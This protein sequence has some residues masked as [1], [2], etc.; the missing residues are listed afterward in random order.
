MFYATLVCSVAAALLFLSPTCATIVTNDTSVATNQTFDYVIVGAGLAG[1]TV[2]NKLSGAGN[3]VLII[4]AGPDPRW[5]PAVY[6]AEER[7]NLDGYC[8]WQYPAYDD[9]GNTLDWTIDSGMCIGGGTSINGLMWYRPT[10]AE[11]NKLE[12]LGNPGWNWESLEPYMIAAERNHPPD[13]IQ[14]AQGAGY[15]PSRH[16]YSGAIN[17]SFPTPMRIPTVQSRFKAALPRIFPGLTIG[18]DLS[19]RSPTVSA[20]SSWT[21]WYDPA[22][23]K[24]R[25]SSAAD[26]LLWAEDQWRERLTVLTNHR[27]DRVIFD[28]KLAATGVAFSAGPERPPSVVHA[29]KE[30]ILAAGALQSAPVLERS[31][32]GSKAVLERAGIQQLVDLPGVGA[33]LNDQPGT[34]TSALVR[35]AYW[36][37]TG[38]ID[39]RI[40]FAPEISLVGLDEVWGADA[41]SYTSA[42]TSIEGLESRAQA[43]VSVGAAANIEGAK[44]ILNTTIDLIVNSDQPVAEFIGESYPTIL[45]AAFWPSMPLSRGHVHINDSYPFSTPVITPRLLTDSFDQE[46]AVAI[47]RRSRALF[48][49]DVFEYVVEN[50][51]YDP[52]IGP[53]GTDAEYLEWYKSTAYGASHWIGST[54]MMPRDLGGVVD[55]NLK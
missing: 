45:F 34:G 21:I 55:S 46:I 18:N 14:I 9:E 41:T 44:H 5:N 12:T 48:A 7:G 26:G 51:Y 37:N 35:E 17:V 1:I 43:L 28:K 13:D 54:A 20:S 6:N 38:I 10:E 11:L 39:D 50:A 40:L 4:E 23:G 47:A 25:R 29:I 42:L 24:N 22:S 15:D 30:V 36:N 19:N 27:V 52:P 32:I 16:G 8:N 33:N 53:N 2:G 31:G 49:S 3:S